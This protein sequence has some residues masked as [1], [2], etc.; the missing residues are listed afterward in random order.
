MSSY[1]FYEKY[2]KFT[3]YLKQAYF[4]GKLCSVKETSSDATLLYFYEN[5]TAGA[6]DFLNENGY[7]CY[8]IGYDQGEAVKGIMK[9]NGFKDCVVKTVKMILE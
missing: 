5:I 6:G 7:L 4:Y 2:R 9:K 3:E 8:E 1:K